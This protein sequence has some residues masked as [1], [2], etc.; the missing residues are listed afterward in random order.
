MENGLG[1]ML[2]SESAESRDDPG[3]DSRTGLIGA[4]RPEIL[5][6]PASRADV[7]AFFGEIPGTMRALAA[8]MDGEVVG[9]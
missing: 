7:E 3:G 5:I 2:T 9:E 1:D 8:E 4:P 6:R